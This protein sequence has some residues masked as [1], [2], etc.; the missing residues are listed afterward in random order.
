L[1]FLYEFYYDA[2]IHDQQVPEF[3]VFLSCYCDGPA[4][5]RITY[6]N[7]VGPTCRRTSDSETQEAI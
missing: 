7:I 6:V 3:S 2:R 4:L 1:D 5:F